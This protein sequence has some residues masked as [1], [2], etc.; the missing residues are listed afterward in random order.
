M[1]LIAVGVNAAE[2]VEVELQNQLDTVTLRLQKMVEI[3][4]QEKALSTIPATQTIAKKLQ[5]TLGKIRS[6][7][8]L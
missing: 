3:T 2:H 1:I 7:N 6:N 5:G 8:F 4:V